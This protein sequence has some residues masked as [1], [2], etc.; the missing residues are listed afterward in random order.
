M[1][2]EEGYEKE[3][4]RTSTGIM[5]LVV[6]FVLSWIPYILYLGALISFIGAILVIIGR[7]AF[8]GNHGRNVVMAVV[9]YILSTLAGI[10]VYL[11]FE[12]SLPAA[13]VSASALKGLFNTYLVS[14]VVVS[15]FTSIAEVLL[16]YS[17][18]DS[19]G[20]KLL[21]VAFILQI[22]VPG[23]ILALADVSLSHAIDLYESTKSISYIHAVVNELN[24]YKLLDVIP[25]IAFAVAYY[26][27]RGRIESG[28]I[29]EYTG[30]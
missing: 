11:Y 28:E 23:I 30:T 3:V 15:V 17:L 2:S 26:F 22:L 21:I 8:G 18:A 25:A 13:I 5:L 12:G 1:Y 7:E 6:G 27:A 10:S 29:P 16:V 9:I 19:F 14:L 20:R 4:E 24:I